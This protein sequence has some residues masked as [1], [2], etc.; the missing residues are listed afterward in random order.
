MNDLLDGDHAATAFALV[1]SRQQLDRAKEM[2]SIS[3]QQLAR[4]MDQ[5][6]VGQTVPLPSLAPV[7]YFAGVRIYLSYVVLTPSDEAPL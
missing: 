1:E 2:V 6:C 3:R 7:C 5:V 4:S